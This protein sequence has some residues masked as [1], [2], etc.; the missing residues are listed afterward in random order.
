MKKQKSFTQ[1]LDNDIRIDIVITNKEKIYK[2]TLVYKRIGRNYYK[3]IGKE[4]EHLKYLYNKE[5]IIE[6]LG[7]KCFHCGLKSPYPEIYDVHHLNPRNKKEYKNNYVNKHFKNIKDEL[8]E[9]VLLCAN[10]HRIIHYK[11]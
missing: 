5:Q 4:K 3:N 6:Y 1:Y 7:G 9:C 8:D 2:S 10:C 11:H